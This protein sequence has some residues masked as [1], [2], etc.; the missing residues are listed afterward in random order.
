MH[1]PYFIDMNNPDSGGTY[2]MIQYMVPIRKSKG[3]TFSASTR[4]PTSQRSSPARRPPTA[5]QRELRRH[6]RRRNTRHRPGH[7]GPEPVP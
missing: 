3:Y 4:S 6:A 7:D 2:Q 1:D 5:A